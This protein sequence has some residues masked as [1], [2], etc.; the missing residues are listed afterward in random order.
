MAPAQRE[1]VSSLMKVHGRTYSSELGIRLDRNTP[2]PLFQLLCAAL[3]FSTRISADA[4]ASAAKALY[5]KGWTT[6]RKLSDSTWRERTDVL[7]R[8]GYARYDE[9][10]SRMLGET[11]DLLQERY[12]GDLRRLREESGRD[13]GKERERL[14]EFK[15]IGDN[16]A[17]IFCRE[18]QL[19]WPELYPFVDQKARKG[20]KG[21]ELNPDPTVL[22]N[23]VRRSD[24]PKLVAALVRVQLA[25]NFEEILN[26][27]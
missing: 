9:S 7:N 3:L 18:V 24:F 6:P 4:A 10:T 25:G 2:A 12:K 13:P 22:K 15:G 1:I 17:D 14:Q 16:G 5:D 11:A 19:Q 20:A 8:A 26:Q 27:A 21:L 23:M